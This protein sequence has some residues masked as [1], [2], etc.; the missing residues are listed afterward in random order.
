LLRLQRAAQRDATIEGTRRMSRWSEQWDR[1]PGGVRAEKFS[2]GGLSLEWLTPPGA[3]PDKVIVYFHGGGFV[4]P[5]YKPTVAVAA[6][7]ARETGRRALLVRYRI[8]PEDP[9]PAAIEDCAAAYR[10]LISGGRIKPRD[11]TL[12]GESAGGNLVIT[13]MLALRDS[14]DPLPAGGAALSGVFDLGDPRDLSNTPD[15]PMIWTGFVQRQLAAYIGE[16]DPGDPR[17]SP[18]CA[19]LS[20]LPPLLIQSGAGEFLR[21]DAERLAARAREC[22][23]DAALDLWPGMWHFWHLFAPFLPE[24]RGAIGRVSQFIRSL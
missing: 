12:L 7:I 19:D 13:A 15:D 18:V 1:F 14:G 24:A 3:D 6:E 5:A 4:F 21:R 22:G 23:V 17:M 10:W 20:G 8:A 9:F 2:A 11:V 16:A